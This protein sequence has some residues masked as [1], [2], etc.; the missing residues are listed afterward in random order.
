MLQ[1]A[2]NASR[3]DWATWGIGIMRS[4]LSGGAAAMLTGGGGA[5]AGITA[6][7]QYIMMISSFIGM[8]IYRLGE[9]LQLHGAPDPIAAVQDAE[10]ASKEITKQAVK[11][12]SAVQDIK[13]QGE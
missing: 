4:F 3:Y 10:A 13:K 8:G 1:A 7:Q 11:L 6:K 9:F 2:H 5:I 12:D